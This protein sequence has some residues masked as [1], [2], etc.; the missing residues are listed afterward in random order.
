MR[1]II[2]ITMLI[3]MGLSVFG[4]GVVE[5]STEFELKK[6]E[7]KAILLVSFGTTYPETRKKTI[8]ALKNEFIK[9]FTDFKVEQAFTSR[10]IIR[11]IKEKEG[12]IINNPSEAL[13]KLKNEG[14]THVLVQAT[15]IMNASEAETLKEEINKHKTDFKVLKM[16]PP[17]LTGV[18]DYRAVVKALKPYYENLK[19]DEALVM[20]GHGT[21]HPGN[22]AY[23][24]LEYMF[25]HEVNR[26]IFIGT[27]EGYP[28]LDTVMED[29]KRNKIK[30]VE[31]YPFMI[32]SGDHSH[33]DI[34]G[35]MKKKLE[36]NGYEVTPHYI[37][38]GENK[39]LREIYI[40]HAK[41]TIKNKVEDM[42]AKKKKYEK[43]M[44]VK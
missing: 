16:S 34:N 29:L 6:G 24:M 14:Y 7:K 5:K 10:I 41:N 26:N 19:S 12:I 37:G 40:N 32:V 30:K 15:H 13:E 3:L 2:V 39:G 21:H 8:T 11:R 42:L 43:G 17:M 18:E 4:E 20:I 44:E 33:H 1:K 23:A 9:E 27:V 25:Q 28:T 35:E 31:L 38:L 36:A 22:S